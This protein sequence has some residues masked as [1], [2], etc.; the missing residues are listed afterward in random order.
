MLLPSWS[1]YRS[2]FEVSVPH[3]GTKATLLKPNRNK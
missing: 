2:I 3:F 1:A